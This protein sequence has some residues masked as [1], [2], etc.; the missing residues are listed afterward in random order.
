MWNRNG[1]SGNP[2]LLSDFRGIA[3]ILSIQVNI[4][5]GFS[6]NCL[7]YIEVYPSILNMARTLVMK[8]Y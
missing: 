2:Q 3:L 6:V 5:Y 7:Y 8:K 1:E 4:G